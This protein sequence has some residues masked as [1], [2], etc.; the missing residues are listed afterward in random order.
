MK[1][2]AVKTIYD[3]AKTFFFSFLFLVSAE[4]LGVGHEF[5]E[6]GMNSFVEV[7]GAS[8]GG[9]VSGGFAETF[10]VRRVV[11]WQPFHKVICATRLSSCLGRR[12]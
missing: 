12:H 10:V 9:L 4:G 2:F 1:P 3:G 7:R 11:S 8:V 5:M 6:A